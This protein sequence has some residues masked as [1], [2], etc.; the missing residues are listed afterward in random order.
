MTIPIRFYADAPLPKRKDTASKYK[1]PLTWK[2]L[3]ITGAIGSSLLMYML[4]LKGKKEKGKLIFITNN[5][6]F[7][8]SKGT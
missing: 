8:V 4:Y 6:G 1:S 5:N 2:N 3:V 7:K